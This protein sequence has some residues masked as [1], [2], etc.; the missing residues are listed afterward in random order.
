[1]PSWG[2]LQ[3]LSVR[4]ETSWAMLARSKPGREILQILLIGCSSHWRVREPE[5]REDQAG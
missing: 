5:L 1:M 2:R 3:H 4:A